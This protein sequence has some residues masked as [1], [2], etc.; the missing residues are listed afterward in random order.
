[1]TGDMFSGALRALFVIGI[2]VGA[3]VVGAVWLFVKYAAPH[4]HIG[5]S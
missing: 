1:M 2:I 3:A 4:I 5:W